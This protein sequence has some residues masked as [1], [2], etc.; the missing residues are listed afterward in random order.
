MTQVRG[1]FE[2]GLASAIP[3]CVLLLSSEATGSSMKCL[4]IVK[5]PPT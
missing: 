2:G 1:H 5:I 4:S 3:I